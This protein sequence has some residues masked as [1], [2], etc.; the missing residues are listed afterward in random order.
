MLPDAGLE[1][2]QKVC[3]KSAILNKKSALK[4]VIKKKCIKECLEILNNKK[5]K[6]LINV[7]IL[8]LIQ[9]KYGKYSVKYR[10]IF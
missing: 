4:L 7:E 3:Q 5:I 6:L 8:E 1:K 2:V 10:V 9:K